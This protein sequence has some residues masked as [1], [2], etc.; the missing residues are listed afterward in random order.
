MASFHSCGISPVWNDRLK[1]D[2]NDGAS[3]LA[4]SLSRRFWNRVKPGA[5]VG[6]NSAEE[7]FD[8][9]LG[10]RDFLKGT[11]DVRG[12]VDGWSLLMRIGHGQLAL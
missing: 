3:S 10:R 11:E 9:S 1:R 4:A 5:F 2:D 8:L 6:I 7:F 12:G